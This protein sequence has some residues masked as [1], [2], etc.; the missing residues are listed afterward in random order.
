M[1]NEKPVPM[2]WH[3]RTVKF[4]MEKT[5]RPRIK[6][7]LGHILDEDGNVYFTVHREGEDV[8]S[9]DDLPIKDFVCPET[10]QLIKY[11]KENH[12]GPQLGI[13]EGV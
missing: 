5:T 1:C 7:I 4:P 13:F 12:L 8:T 10:I 9:V 3:K 6:R 2:F 11:C